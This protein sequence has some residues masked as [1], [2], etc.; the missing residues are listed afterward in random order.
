MALGTGT[1]ATPFPK[2]ALAYDATGNC[3]FGRSLPKGGLATIQSLPRPIQVLLLLLLLLSSL[4]RKPVV[5]VV[6][7]VVIRVVACAHAH[8]GCN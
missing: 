2:G 5:V 6:V 1:S 8:G 3:D 4:T 7:V